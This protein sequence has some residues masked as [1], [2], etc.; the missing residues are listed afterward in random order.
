MNFEGIRPTLGRLT[1]ST[2]SNHYC[3][4][5]YAA[6]RPTPAGAL[7]RAVWMV[8]FITRRGSYWKQVYLCPRHLS[9]LGARYA[10][11]LAARTAASRKKEEAVAAAIARLRERRRQR[12]QRRQLA[13]A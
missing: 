10:D 13:A 11:A 12:Q 1:P 4:P 6:I 8:S 5:C 9:A 7:R 3:A 2:H